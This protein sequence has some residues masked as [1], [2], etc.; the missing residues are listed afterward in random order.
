MTSPIDVFARA[1]LADTGESELISN[2]GT[3]AFKIGGKPPALIARPLSHEAAARVL[4]RANEA[5]LA[6]VPWG[7]GTGRRMGYPPARYDVVL[8]TG[9]LSETVDFLRDDLT[10]VVGAGMT[11]SALNRLTEPNGQ[12]A[13][14]DPPYPDQATVGGTIIAERSGP[15]RVR[16][17]RA[18]D[19]VMRMRIVLA[20]GSTQTYGALVVKNVTGYDMNRLLAG[21]WGTLA[22]VT[23]LA[24]RLF[25][26]PDQVGAIAGGFSS[27]EAVFSAGRQLS[28]TP[29]SPVWME[30]VGTGRI[31]E[32]GELDEVPG[33]PFPWCLVA[34]YG[35][36]EEG[37]DQM[38]AQAEEIVQ[39]SGGA[40]LRRFGKEE[41]ERLGQ[42][43]AD[44][45]GGPFSGADGLEF[46][47][48]ARLDQLP[49]MAA[50]AEDAARVGGYQL[51]V[52]A[53]AA[54]GVL[55]CWLAPV[56]DSPSPAAAWDTFREGCRKGASPQK[57]RAVHL[58]LSGAPDSLRTDTEVWGEDVLPPAT[59]DLMRRL[60]A[61]YDPMGTLSPGRFVARI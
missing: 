12:T 17:G 52:A 4:A 3:A 48:S 11:I 8:S 27:A 44:P 50:A 34:A 14:F 46:R 61:E 15:M 45:P 43:L 21:S 47:A 7:G 5:G 35:D 55:R 39:K 20:D 37:L 28:A 60:K 36:F 57:G 41:T 59:I 29:L 33:L 22:V 49:R 31:N 42:V 26:K 6:V 1:V 32:L 58:S 19:R 10:V 40:D 18:R 53:H 54:N 13:G 38:L 25:K 30:V 2:E 23:E 9:G 24:V 16:Y 56:G 51:A